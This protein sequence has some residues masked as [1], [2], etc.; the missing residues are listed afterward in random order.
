MATGVLVELRGVRQLRDKLGKFTFA[1]DAEAQS[2]LEDVADYAV[3]VARGAAPYDMG[4]LVENIHA[5][6]H[7]FSVSVISSK[8]YSYTQEFGRTA[9]ARQPS[10][11]VIRPWAERHGMKGRDR[12]WQ[13]ARSI[14]RKGFKGK[15]FMTKAARSAD[16]FLRQRLSK[17]SAK[18]TAYWAI[19]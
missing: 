14:G 6:A 5:E 9:G 11:D 18:L 7:T 10:T 16:L 2:I 4:G 15:F 1:V 8:D 17:A 19:E 12:A 13:I 3:D